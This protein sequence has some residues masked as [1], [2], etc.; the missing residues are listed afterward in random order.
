MSARR[1]DANFARHQLGTASIAIVEFSDFQCPF[2][3]RHALETLPSI[4]EKLVR[5]GKA[6]YIALH[7]PIEAIHPQAVGAAVAAECAGQKGQFWEMHE[8]LFGVGKALF[9]ED[10]VRY[11]QELNLSGSDFTTCMEG[12]ETQQIVKADRVEA[13]RLGVKGTPVFFVGTVRADGTIELLRR[14]N[15]ATT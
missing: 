7:Y 2:C 8:K 1:L 11:A 4:K 12:A 9:K 13:A 10:L 6:R 5:A 15:G 3:S 14:I